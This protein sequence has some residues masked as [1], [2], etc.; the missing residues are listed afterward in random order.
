MVRKKLENKES[1]RRSPSG[2]TTKRSTLQEER[3]MYVRD[4]LLAI[5]GAVEKAAEDLYLPIDTDVMV[6]TGSTV[7]DLNISG[8]RIRGGGLPGGIVA[9]VYGPPSA[10]KTVF[11]SEL[12]ASVQ[13][14]GGEFKIEDGEARLDVGFAQMF[15][16]EISEKN[17]SRTQSVK[18]IITNLNNWNPKKKDTIN[19]YGV[20]GLALLS[21]KLDQKEEGDKRG[22]QRAKELYELARKCCIE[23]AQ[24]HKLV[25]FTNHELETSV[26]LPGGGTATKKYTP[27]GNGPK[28]LASLRMRIVKVKDITPSRTFGAIKEAG[29]K[30]KSITQ[31]VGQECRVKIIKSSIDMYPRECT[32]FI[33]GNMVDDIRGNL[34]YLKDIYNLDKYECLGKEYATIDPAIQYIEENN[35]EAELR[36]QVIDTWEAANSLFKSDRK[37]KVRF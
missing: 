19:L 27:G 4:R 26:R 5:G 34:V 29:I 20:D 33:M 22:Q 16:C 10:G 25:V 7:L 15:G 12:A 6:S 18:E 21:S 11:L 24:R 8:G 14:H 17:Y 1:E 3:Q 35:L 32:Y 37:K 28:F 2:R 23:I 30:G 36:E 13:Y 9:E 31:K